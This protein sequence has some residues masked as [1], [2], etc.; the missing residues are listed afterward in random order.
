M[1]ENEHPQKDTKNET[2]TDT[3]TATATLRNLTAESAKAL[4]QLRTQRLARHG[5]WAPLIDGY[6]QLVDAAIG[7]AEAASADR[8]TR[9]AAVKSLRAHVQLRLAGITDRPIDL[10]D[11]GSTVRVLARLAETELRIPG[12]TSG[13]DVLLGLIEG[14]ARGYHDFTFAHTRARH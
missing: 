5:R 7:V 1:T 9:L 10:D 11:L 12:L 14:G 6:E 2:K 3:T 8:P 13:A 4:A